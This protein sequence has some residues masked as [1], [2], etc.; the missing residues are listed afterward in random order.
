MILELRFRPS[1]HDGISDPHAQLYVKHCGKSDE[2][3]T[4]L[5]ADCVTFEEL[6]G[7]VKVLEDELAQIRKTGRKRFENWQKKMANNGDEPIR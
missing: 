1:E 6:D 2:G 3:L 4:T 5:G 7:Q